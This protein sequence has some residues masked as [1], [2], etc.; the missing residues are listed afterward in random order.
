MIK[1]IDL[2]NLSQAQEVFKLQQIAYSVEASY[3]GTREIPPLQEDLETLRASQECFI[4]YYIE[5]SL[6]GVI[7][8]QSQKQVLDIHRLFVDPAFFGQGIAEKL[9]KEL[10]KEKHQQV[11]VT[12]GTKNQPAINFYLKQGFK[13]MKVFEVA[14]NLSLTMFQKRQ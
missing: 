8:Y 4:G 12:T 3:L 1:K 5:E 7:S 2:T 6:V 13:Q 9:L 11:I 10:E 14:K